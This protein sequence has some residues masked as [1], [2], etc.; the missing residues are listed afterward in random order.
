MALTGVTQLRVDPVM[1]YNFAVTLLESSD[2]LFSVLSALQLSA[3]GG[4]SE[5]SGLDTTLEVEEYKEGGNNGAILKFPTRVTWA[6]IKLK[7]GV[8]VSN[9]LWDWHYQFAAGFGT[10]RDGLIVLFDSER[11]PV[12]T[13]TFRRGLP[14]KYAGPA[15][16]ASQGQVAV[17]EMEIAHEGLFLAG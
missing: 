6:N 13:W 10:R 5:C 16:N 15:M 12:R 3:A 4:F 1:N 8:T 7:R 17:E 11:Q 2:L 14:V 9:E